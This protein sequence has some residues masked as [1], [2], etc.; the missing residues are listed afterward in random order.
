MSVCLI[1][2]GANIS[3]RRETLDQAV[4]H[5]RQHPRLRITAVSRW[6]R[7]EAVGG[8][9]G[10]PPFLNGAA[11]AETDLPPHE[12]LELLLSLEQQLGRRRGERWAPRR[13]DLDLLLYDRLQ[14]DTPSLVL[15]HPR[16][17]WRPF[18]LQPAAEIAPDMLHP[19]T[20]WTIRRLLDH[21]NEAFPYVAIAGAI[22]AGKTSLAR[23]MA[24]AVPARLIA[25]DPDSELLGGFYAD[26][27]S[28][29]WET[30]L[31]FLQ[32]RVELL[33]P[34]AVT[35]GEPR[36]VV[37]D[38]WFDQSAAFARAW[39]AP[40][41]YEAFAQR[42]LDARQRVMRPKLLVLLDLPGDVLAERVRRRGRAYEQ[43]LTVEQLD[44]IGR[45]VVEQTA[46]SHE[47]PL[48]RLGLE[49]ADRADAEA[50]AAV[51]AM[52]GPCVAV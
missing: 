15:P 50:I 47:G 3:P 52:E 30:E 49:D 46:D 26:P 40:E 17:A 44:R 51:E 39:L 41:R 35:S 33:A 31:Q 14:L 28:R 23:A 25:E 6:Y 20:G 12:V 2:L 45:F 21:L 22:G 42:W 5:L 8:P 48:L 1:G 7:S 11:L 37:S 38:F 16:M 34:E 10:Q 19:P 9:A 18:V 29:G 32:H 27:S 13:L 43:R 4:A 24:Q 36:P